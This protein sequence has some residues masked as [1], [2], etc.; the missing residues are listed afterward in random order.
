[1]LP[2]KFRED[3]GNGTGAV[4][5]VNVKRRTPARRERLPTCLAILPWESRV[6]LT[7]SRIDF[8]GICRIATTDHL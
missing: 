3:I 4:F 2:R 1:M 8:T 7:L 6:S 5:A